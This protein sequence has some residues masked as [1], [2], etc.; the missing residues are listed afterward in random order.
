MDVAGI[1]SEKPRSLTDSII[2]TLH[3]F[4]VINA[5]KYHEFN[6]LLDEFNN[7]EGAE[8][9]ELRLNY[10]TYYADNVFIHTS[11]IKQINIK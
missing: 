4:N 7:T 1:F 8:E 9:K 10:K 5:D 3:L 6:Q 11:S 2:S